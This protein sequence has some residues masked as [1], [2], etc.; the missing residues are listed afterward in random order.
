MNNYQIKTVITLGPASDSE[1]TI[2]KF[3]AGGASIFRLNFSHNTPDYFGRLIDMI[4]DINARLNKHVSILLDLPG[5]KIRTGNPIGGKLELLEG[6]TYSLGPDCQIPVSRQ[7]LSELPSKGGIKLADG[8]LELKI[9]DKLKGKLVVRAMNS[10]TLLDRQSIN[11]QGL[12]YERSYPTKNDKAAISFGLKKGITS[13]ALSFVSRKKDVTK[14]RD[15]VGEDIV[16]V[17]KI[18]RREALRNFKEIAIAS[19]AIM[20]A[21]GD[22][23]LNIDIAEV[24]LVQRKLIR[25]S[26]QLRRPVITATQMLESMTTNVM[27][28]RAEVNDVFNSVYEGSDAVMLSEETAIGAYPLR[29]FEMLKRITW[30]SQYFDDPQEH[31]ESGPH[32]ALVGAAAY[33]ISSAGVKNV[34]FLTRGGAG[35]INLS[36]YHT[37]ARIFALTDK[38]NVLDKLNIARGVEPFYFENL[39][40]GVRKFI[41]GAG[42]RF[43]IKGTTLVIRSTVEHGPANSLELISI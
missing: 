4:N 43:G 1:Q 11:S 13:F 6:E 3:A 42:R 27:P 15:I 21:R 12:L 5:P 41:D 28:T 23:G 35:P 17:S 40:T 20:I 19:D 22:L 18:E 25:A 16:L 37:N 14:V 24:P 7:I 34:V 8:K 39:D 32:E 29:A 31:R 26:N 33:I 30:K 10:G 36:R 9:I 2:K 38:K